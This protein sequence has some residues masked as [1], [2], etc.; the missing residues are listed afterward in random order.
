[1]KA[2]K[3][4]DMIVGM[5]KGLEEGDSTVTVARENKDAMAEKTMVLNILNRIKEFN[6]MVM[7]PDSANSLTLD[8]E[9]IKNFIEKL[10]PDELNVENEVT[11]DE[12]SATQA[13]GPA[14]L[15][16]FVNETKYL[17]DMYVMETELAIFD[18]HKTKLHDLD[19]YFKSLDAKDLLDLGFKIVRDKESNHFSIPFYIL[20]LLPDDTEVVSIRKTHDLYTGLMLNRILTVR[21]AKYIIVKK[22][23]QRLDREA[24]RVYETN[25]DYINTSMSTFFALN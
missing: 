5:D 16:T 22:H 19:T 20:F 13:E 17:R 7:D 3:V 15:D 10:V 25:S 9:L 12:Q 23:I 1:M 24:H 6:L 21:M 14:I 4:E 18:E 8:V 11:H 2:Y